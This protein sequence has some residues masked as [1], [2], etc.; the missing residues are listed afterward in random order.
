MLYTRTFVVSVAVILLTCVVGPASAQEALQGSV[1]SALEAV[2]GAQTEDDRAIA[3][4]KL[5]AHKPATAADVHALMDAVRQKSISAPIPAEVLMNADDPQLVPVFMQALD[6]PDIDVQ[7]ASVRTLGKMKAREAAP[8]LI[9]KF[10][11][12]P[13]ELMP[14]AN[15]NKVELKQTAQLGQYLAWALGRMGD[16]S[17]VPVLIA[18]PEFYFH[19]F[20]ESPLAMIGAPAVPALLT[21]AKDKKDPRREKVCSIISSIK[22]PAAV[23]ALTAALKDQEADSRLKISAFVALAK[24]G[25]PGIDTDARA[26]L[27]D[28][29]EVARLGALYWMVKYDKASYTPKLREFLHDK[30]WHIRA[31][32]AQFAGELGVNETVPRLIELLNDTNADVQ[33]NSLR[34]LER[35]FKTKAVFSVLDDRRVHAALTIEG[36]KHEAVIADIALVREVRQGQR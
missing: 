1:K 15:A 34:A 3:V 26:L 27:T 21:V 19:E 24:M 2:Q 35:L 16:P 29:D 32:T 22:D 8:L 5:K 13:P 14:S 10:K 33:G 18:R 12:L 11:S 6:D 9:K 30:S 7:A 20:G 28:K 4:Q 36:E 23:P 17:A 25:A 31:V